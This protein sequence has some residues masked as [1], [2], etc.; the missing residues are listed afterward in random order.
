MKESIK[1]VVFSSP[2][3]VIYISIIAVTLYHFNRESF[4]PLSGSSISQWKNIIFLL[5]PMGF[6]P[7][8]GSS[9]SQLIYSVTEETIS[10]VFVPSRGHL[11]LN[12]IAGLVKEAYDINVFVP[13]RGHLY[14]NKKWKTS[15][16][17][18]LSVFVPSRGHLY[19]N[20]VFYNV[21][22]CGYSFRP[23][24]GSSISQW[25]IAHMDGEAYPVFVPSRGHLYLNTMSLER[26]A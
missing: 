25:Y 21:Y 5:I 18:Q 15:W 19:L 11:Y 4:R 8:S 26:G 23:L 13:S 9:I 10:D 20:S 2:L 16:L 17:P 7:L 12:K 14:L 3:G 24:S 22:I 1:K 6:R